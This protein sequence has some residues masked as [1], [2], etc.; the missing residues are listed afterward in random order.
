MK[1]CSMEKQNKKY[2]IPKKKKKKRTSK[3]QTS[4]RLV[5]LS[6]TVFLLYFLQDTSL[7]VARKI[8]GTQKSPDAGQHY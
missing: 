1:R 4:L 6:H 3:L 7:I 5:L 2:E 8:C